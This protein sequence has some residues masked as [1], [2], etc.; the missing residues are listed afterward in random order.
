MSTLFSK[1]EEEFIKDLLESP[2][3]ID[4]LIEK[5]GAGYARVLKNRIWKKGLKLEDQVWMF[6][7]AGNH[8]YMQRDIKRSERRL[9]Y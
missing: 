3:L 9:S 4:P 1:R 5:W 2:G 7:E 8:P 6:R